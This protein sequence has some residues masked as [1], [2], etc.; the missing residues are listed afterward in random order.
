MTGSTRA[1]KADEPM[2]Q[3]QEHS[4]HPTNRLILLRLVIPARRIDATI[5]VDSEA[6]GM[7][8]VAD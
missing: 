1:L 2:L 3:V 4:E 6:N 5:S 7:L 8:L